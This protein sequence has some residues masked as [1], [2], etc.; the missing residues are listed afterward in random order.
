MGI[1]NVKVDPVRGILS[2]DDGKD[3]LSFSADV[4]SYALDEDR[5]ILFVLNNIDSYPEELIILD[6]Q[7][8]ELDKIM[9][10]ENFSFSYLSSSEDGVSIICGGDE[11]VDGH[12]DWRFKYDYNS[13]LLDRVGPAR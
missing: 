5:N 1:K 7:G 12:W 13:G 6:S 2:W 11:V 4:D 8:N 9:S 10:P 3:R